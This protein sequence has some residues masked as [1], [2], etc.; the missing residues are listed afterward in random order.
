MELVC[1]YR[2]RHQSLFSVCL[3]IPTAHSEMAVLFG[4]FF[5]SSKREVCNGQGTVDLSLQAQVLMGLAP[6][7]SSTHTLFQ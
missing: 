6:Y 5:P 4:C 3:N 2:K 1:F 7:M